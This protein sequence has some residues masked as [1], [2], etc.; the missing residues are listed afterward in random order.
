MN[1]LMHMLNGGILSPIRPYLVIMLLHGPSIFKSLQGRNRRRLL[2]RSRLLC[3]LLY[4][5]NHVI[6]KT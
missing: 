2:K 6:Q 1:A 3:R 5:L 4:Y